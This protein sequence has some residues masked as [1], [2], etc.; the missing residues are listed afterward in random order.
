M[1]AYLATAALPIY[2]LH[3]PILVTVA[4]FVV[5]W[6]VPALVKYAVIVAISFVVIFVVYDLCVRRTRPTRFLFGIR[7]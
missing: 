6:Q 7:D 2:I 4:Y 5:R 1:Y 3:Q